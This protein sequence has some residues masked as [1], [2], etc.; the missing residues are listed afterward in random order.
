MKLGKDGALFH[1]PK[2]RCL[3]F[4]SLPDIQGLNFSLKFW[5]AYLLVA[6]PLVRVEVGGGGTIRSVQAGFPRLV[7]A[8]QQGALQ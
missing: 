1:R 6:A 2:P 3:R 4:R 7:V 5:R 8:M